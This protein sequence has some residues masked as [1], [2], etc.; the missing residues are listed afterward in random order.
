M[1]K[2]KLLGLLYMYLIKSFIK[3]IINKIS[4]LM[5]QKTFLDAHLQN[6]LQFI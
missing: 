4:S 2:D 6:S 5:K 3:V 1:S